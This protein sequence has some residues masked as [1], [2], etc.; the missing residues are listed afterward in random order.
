MEAVSLITGLL[1]FGSFSLADKVLSYLP[2]DMAK[3]TFTLPVAG[4]V[5]AIS[6]ATGMVFATKVPALITTFCVAIMVSTLVLIFLE[7][8]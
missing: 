3:R 7:R 1:A 4:A 2:D 5:G 6:A 8:G